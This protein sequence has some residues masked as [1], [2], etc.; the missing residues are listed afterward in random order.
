LLLELRPRF[1]RAG[2]WK[3]P[4]RFLA[5]RLTEVGL[6]FAVKSQA[7]E[8]WNCH[9]PMG[10]GAFYL[11]SSLL[12]LLWCSLHPQRGLACMPGGWLKGR[13][14]KKVILLGPTASA[15]LETSE[16][17]LR[18]LFSGQ[19]AEFAT[20]IRERAA[21]QNHPFEASFREA[22]LEALVEFTEKK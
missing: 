6:E 16:A 2:T 3:G 17:Q 22:E 20:W 21:G 19:A 9:G 15:D 1:N 14:K 10:A 7:E 13:I 4:Q 8:G 5:W 12:R 11:R 18:S